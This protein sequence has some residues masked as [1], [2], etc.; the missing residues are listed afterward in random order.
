MLNQEE[1]EVWATP[2]YGPTVPVKVRTCQ[3]Q[4][5]LPGITWEVMELFLVIVQFLGRGN[6]QFQME[7]GSLGRWPHLENQFVYERRRRHQPTRFERKRPFWINPA[8]SVSPAER[9]LIR[10]RKKI[11]QTFYSQG[12]ILNKLLGLM[13]RPGDF[14]CCSLSSRFVR[15]VKKW[16]WSGVNLRSPA[17]SSIVNNLITT[18][19]CI[20]LSIFSLLIWSS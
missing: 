1:I 3:K 4:F 2:S 10:N 13:G 18:L 14:V 15:K 17:L 6:P 12:T 5:G 19:S 16:R 11:S 8:K 9:N 7:I 20:S